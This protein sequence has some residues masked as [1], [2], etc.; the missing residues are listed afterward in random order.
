MSQAEPDKLRSWRI[1][2]PNRPAP[3]VTFEI[4]SDSTWR[5]DLQLKP[6]V[7]QEMGVKEYFAYDLGQPGFWRVKRKPTPVRLRGWEYKGEAITELKPNPQ[8][9]LWSEQLN[10]WL[11]PDG[12]VLRIHT[13]DGERCL[14][15]LESQQAEMDKLLAKLKA[16]GIDPDSL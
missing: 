11:V 13:A 3:T 2:Q 8:G 9:W 10:K 5:E 4:A 7:Y 16:K 1:G 15:E 12:R 6:E 14:D